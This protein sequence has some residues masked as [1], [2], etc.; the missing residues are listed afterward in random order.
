M[1]P[2]VVFHHEPVHS[3]SAAFFFHG[4]FVRHTVFD[5]VF[6]CP[7]LSRM[8]GFRLKCLS[9][10]IETRVELASVVALT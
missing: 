4:K 5:Q 8:V 3:K 10:C 7:L 6:T 1:Q 9:Q 2:E